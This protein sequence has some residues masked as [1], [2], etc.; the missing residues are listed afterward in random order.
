MAKRLIT[1]AVTNTEDDYDNE[2]LLYV[3]E[4][5]KNVNDWRTRSKAK[6]GMTWSLKH[7]IAIAK[8]WNL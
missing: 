8:M 5:K 7:W 6:H 4:L 3:K 2:A 1:I